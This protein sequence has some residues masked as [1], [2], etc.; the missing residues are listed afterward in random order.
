MVYLVGDGSIY[1]HA[2]KIENS[3][4]PHLMK[5][6]ATAVPI[7]PEDLEDSWKIPGLQFTKKLEFNYYWQR[8]AEAVIDTFA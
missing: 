3:L 5:L 7:I 4:A 2:K 6:D 1:V 8:M